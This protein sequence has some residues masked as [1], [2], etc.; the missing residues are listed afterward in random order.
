MRR[1]LTA[2]GLAT[3]FVN[4]GLAAL[5]LA[6]AY[7]HLLAFVASPRASVLLIVVLETVFAAFL[8]VRRGAASVSSTATAWTS[9]VVGTFA[10]LLMRPTSATSDPS[11]R[12]R[13]NS[14]A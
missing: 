13:C 3:A 5:Y 9:T 14:S 8:L 12:S 6:F 10:P 7:A 1:Q 4:V 11:S 2:A